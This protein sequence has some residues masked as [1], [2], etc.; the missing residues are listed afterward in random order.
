MSLSR[1]TSPSQSPISH[2]LFLPCFLTPLDRCIIPCYCPSQRSC[3]YPHTLLSHLTP[4]LSLSR[5]NNA[6]F[7]PLSCPHG[8]R[9]D[10]HDRRLSLCVN[11]PAYWKSITVLQTTECPDEDL[12]LLDP[13]TYSDTPS[14]ELQLST[15][16]GCSC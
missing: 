16:G 12:S 11:D 15:S 13:E 9:P 6:M 8:S 1:R 3:P 10:G 2:S 7:P 5:L 14:V 4:S